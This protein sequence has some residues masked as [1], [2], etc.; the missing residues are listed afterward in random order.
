M[1]VED[2]IKNKFFFQ[3][4]LQKVSLTIN[5][6][7][8]ADAGTYYCK[9]SNEL[10]TGYEKLD[11]KISKNAIEPDSFTGLPGSTVQLRCLLNQTPGYR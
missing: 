6:A 11:I 2:V 1:F 5:S 10:G 8:E 4:G 9:A 7:S 3:N